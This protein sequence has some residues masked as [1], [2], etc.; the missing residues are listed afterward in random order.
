LQVKP[1]VSPLQVAVEFEG[2]THGEHDVPQVAVE[3][4]LTHA[5]LQLW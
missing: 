3:V 5:P 2:G 4:L 1:H